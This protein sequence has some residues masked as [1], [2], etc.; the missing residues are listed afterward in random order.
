MI[1]SRYAIALYNISK[2]RDLIQEVSRDLEILNYLLENAE[3]KVLIES[4]ILSHK[5]KKSILSKIDFSTD[6]VSDFSLFLLSKGDFYHFSRIVHIFHKI[7]RKEENILRVRVYTPTA[8][9]DNAK[10]ILL[11]L[12]EKK[13]KNKIELKEFIDKELLGGVKIEFKD[14]VIDATF[15]NYLDNIR[16]TSIV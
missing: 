9:N 1:T 16:K 11:S 8:L 12:L 14:K 15:K 4:P 13:L 6:L 10:N 2:R 5:E 7:W 3:F